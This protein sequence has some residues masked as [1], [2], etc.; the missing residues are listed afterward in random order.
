M[1][2]TTT[3]LLHTMT[4]AWRDHVA[5][6]DIV[7]FHFPCATDDDATAPKA[8]PCLVLDVENIGG[9][10]YA[11]LAYGTTATTGANRGYEIRVRSAEALATAG[12]H[13]PTRF[14]AA[15][16]L[17]VPLDSGGFACCAGTGAPVLGCLTGETRERMH[18]VRARIHAERDIAADRRA[19]RRRAGHRRPS[20]MRPVVVEVRRT[21]RQ[22]VRSGEAS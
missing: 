21:K 10:R 6:G 8:R 12:L 16:R 1:L 9:Q 5:V 18:A 15:R 20:P 4:P 17:L 13:K 3:A 11:L 19:S 2:D 22:A 14:V 7:S